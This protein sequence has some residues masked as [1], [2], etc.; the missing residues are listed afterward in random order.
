[1]EEK[2]KKKEEKNEEMKNNDNAKWYNVRPVFVLV[3]A[4]Q[5]KEAKW[6]KKNRIK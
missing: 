1:M 3:E 6:I 4:G 5:T 2:K